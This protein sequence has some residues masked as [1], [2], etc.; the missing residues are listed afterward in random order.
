M[1]RSIESAIQSF[2]G[3]V[4]VKLNW[5]SAKDA[6]WITFDKT[7]RC[8]TA[9]EVCLLLKSSAF[10]ANDL[11]HAFDD[12]TI[13]I[14]PSK[15]LKRPPKLFIVLRKWTELHPSREFRSFIVNNKLVGICPRDLSFSPDLLVETTQRAIKTAIATFV[16]SHVIRKFPESTGMHSARR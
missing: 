2:G 3:S 12:C 4:F 11:D 13:R 9:G 10:I 8:T 1:I 14:D 6:R 15:P 5:S 7:L 16:V